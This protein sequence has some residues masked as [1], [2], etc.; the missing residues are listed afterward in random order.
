MSTKT[1]NPRLADKYKKEVVP[2]LVKKLAD[3]LISPDSFRD[4]N[5][6]SS[7]CFDIIKSCF[8]LNN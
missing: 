2:A 3:V 5:A 7:K 1:Y 4:A 6:V 8:N